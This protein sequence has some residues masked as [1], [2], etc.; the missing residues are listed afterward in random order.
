M[1]KCSK[2]GQHSLVI[3]CCPECNENIC[4][5]CGVEYNLK[6]HC[7]GCVPKEWLQKT[8][9][10]KIKLSYISLIESIR[11]CETLKKDHEEL[12][13][14]IKNMKSFLEKEAYN[15]SMP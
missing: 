13:E 6:I 2:C 1:K 14:A 15:E 10:R 5:R 12:H 9:V 8:I 7:S 11:H 4:Y 3:K